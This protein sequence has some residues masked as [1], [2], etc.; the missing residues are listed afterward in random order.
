MAFLKYT[1]FFIFFGILFFSCRKESFITSPQAR[2]YTSTDTLSYDTIFTSVGSITKSFK[3]FNN[4]NQKLL[5]TKVKLSGGASSFFKMNVDGI[6]ANEVDGVEINP[7]DSIYVFV[8][9][10]IDPTT[11]NLPFIIT[12]SILIDYNS[13]QN[14][15]QLQ[16]YGQNAVFLNKVKLTGNTTWNDSLP[17]VILGG[18]LVDTN[19]VLTIQAGARIYLHPDAPMLVDGTLIVQGTKQ[20]K[21]VFA[22]DRLDPDYK[23]FPASWPGIYFN[24]SSKENN[25]QFA[26]IRNA[27]QGVIAQDLSLNTIPKLTLSQCIIDNV[28]DAG[29][30]GINSNIYAD[31]CLISNCGKNVLLALGG[32]YSFVHCT[33]A[34]YSNFFIDHKNPVLQLTNFADQGNTTLIADLDARFTNCIF[35]GEGG[36]VENEIAISKKPNTFFSV[37]FDNTLYKVKDNDPADAVFTGNILKNVNPLF[38]SINISKNYYDFH[39]IKDPAAASIDKGSVTTFTK[40][41]D[42]YIRTGIPDLGC[43][44]R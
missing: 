27:Y 24:S 28:Y 36:S 17:Y 26:V 19:A 9:I 5:L 1:S 4:N 29:V 10:K 40:D 44:E 22:G 6:S 30:L 25:I 42:D 2:L 23:D 41:L 16:A 34:S 32:D 37:K 3:I 8:Q 31:N 39:F 7:N 33:I 18:I 14:F 43:Y 11:A 20:D 35:W 21:V 38:D 15:V 12:D 13:N